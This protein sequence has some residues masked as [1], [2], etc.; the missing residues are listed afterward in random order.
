MIED[1]QSIGA[2]AVVDYDICIVGG[3]AAGITLAK[4]LASTGK[5]IVLLVGGATKERADDRDLYRGFSAP[6]TSHEPLEENRRRVW[7]GTTS[8]WGGRCVPLDPMDFEARS[9]I[10]DSG[11]PLRYDELVDYY[12][13]AGRLCESGAFRY[14]ATTSAAAG[15]AEMI[16]G[17][18]ND[19]LASTRLER[20][21]PPIDFGREY[22]AE[23]A[24]SSNVRVLMRAHA[25]RVALDR[26]SGVVRGITAAARPAAEFRVTASRYVLAC[27]GLE[28]PRLLL[29][30]DDVAP[31]GVG[32]HSDQLGRYYMSHLLGIFAWADVVDRG[33]SFRYGFERDDAGVYF[34]RRFWLTE[35]GQ[36][37][38]GVGNA[39]GYF[40]RPPADL[41]QAVHG[42][43]LFSATVLA[44]YYLRLGKR[45]GPRGL[46]AQL[47]DGRAWARQHWR[48]VARGAPGL[49]PQ[50][51][52]LTKSRFFDDRRLPMVLAPKNSDRHYMFFQT[53]HMPNP[54]SRIT[55]HRDRDA[56]GLPRIETHVAFTQL[57]FDTVYRFH[58]VMR[59]RFRDAGV[60]TFNFDESALKERIQNYASTFDSNAHHLGTTRMSKDPA[61]GVVDENCRVHGV[62]NLFVA[63][64][65]VFPTSG[66]A[67][68]TL[69]IVALAV[70]LADHLRSAS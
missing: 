40:F 23:L 59:D 19:T 29:A 44:R 24:Q 9:W 1:A 27:G 61:A 70:R 68:P 25:L 5:R 4:E 43:A 69:T 50:M 13:R 3:G 49:V 58:E 42:D 37:S 15:G 6:G 30:S 7:G 51:A 22:Q 54:D 32:N 52:R 2:G 53:E 34:R 66:H 18:D 63:S 14:D 64:S 21:S 33:D 62:S 36:R 26:E 31:A 17:F 12:E 41:D 47:R 67:N 28:V 11:W 57:D 16:R 60:G 8:A 48:V 56:F 65:S 10:P 39:I 38:N 45:Y 55:L 46:P 20:W 35:D